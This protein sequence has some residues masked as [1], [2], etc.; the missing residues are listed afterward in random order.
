[1]GIEKGQTDVIRLIKDLLKRDKAARQEAK[2]ERLKVEARSLFIEENQEDI[3]KFKAFFVNKCDLRTAKAL[4]LAEHFVADRSLYST[5]KL[6]KA[7]LDG[8]RLSPGFCDFRC[9]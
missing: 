4:K 1:M 2:A 3:T 6:G 7:Y 9:H 8:F 5:R